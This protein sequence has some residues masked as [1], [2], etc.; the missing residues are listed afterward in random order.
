MITS[1]FWIALQG[2]GHMINGFHAP[3]Y[4]WEAM[5]R[6]AKARNERRKLMRISTPP[7]EK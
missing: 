7:D 2:L 5:V 4:L 1:P 3:D 6:R